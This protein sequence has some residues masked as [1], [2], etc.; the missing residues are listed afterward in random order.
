M[1]TYTKW[2]P[3]PQTS[4]PVEGHDSRLLP[5]DTTLS[6]QPRHH[7]TYDRSLGDALPMLADKRALLN[8]KVCVNVLV[9][10]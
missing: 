2:K 3:C 1:Y 10:N 6:S 4:R 5:T 7:V 9:Y 8:C